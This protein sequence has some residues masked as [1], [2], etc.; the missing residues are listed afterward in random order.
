MSAVEFVFG[1]QC[2]LYE[3]QMHTER[4]QALKEQFGVLGYN[5]DFQRITFTALLCLKLCT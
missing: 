3:V 4:F 1:R 2:Q 5:W